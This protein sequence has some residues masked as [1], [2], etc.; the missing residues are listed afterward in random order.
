VGDTIQVD[1]GDTVNN[2]YLAVGA[3]FDAGVQSLLVG[4]PTIVEC[5][6]NVADPD[7]P[8][9]QRRQRL[10]RTGSSRGR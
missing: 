2:V 7:A 1:C 4:A 9:I 5:D 6:P 10:E 3:T 8:K